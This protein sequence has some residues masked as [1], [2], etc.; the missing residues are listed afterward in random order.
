[1]IYPILSGDSPGAQSLNPLYGG[2]VLFDH[3]ED[4][5]ADGG[6]HADDLA[7]GCA[8][9]RGAFGA[10]RLFG[11]AVHAGVGLGGGHELEGHGEG[12]GGVGGVPGFG[13]GGTEL[14]AGLPVMAREGTVSRDEA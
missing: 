10:G 6:D 1:L 9:E 12:A 5:V 7:D 11:G 13:P 2:G 14:R 3:V 8:G 4:D